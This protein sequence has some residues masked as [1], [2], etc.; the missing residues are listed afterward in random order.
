[1]AA[2][3]YKLRH[4]SQFV[5]STNK[6]IALPRLLL[7]WRVNTIVACLVPCR[8]KRLRKASGSTS[9]PRLWISSAPMS[10]RLAQA[11]NAEGLV[12]KVCT[13]FQALTN[14]IKSLGNAQLP[15]K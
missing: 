9:I 4:L 10:A 13:I 7:P 8:C 2:Y 5:G 11:F 1:M 15:V 12:G 3:E 6:A 14:G